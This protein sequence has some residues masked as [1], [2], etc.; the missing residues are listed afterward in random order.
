[1][2]LKTKAYGVTHYEGKAKLLTPRSD[3]EIEVRF[4][5]DATAFNGKK[6]AVFPGKGELNSQITE[7]L[8]GFLERR[9][10][11]TQHLG[12]I[13]ENTLLAH[14]VTI[15]PIEA[16]A[17]FR[18]AGSLQ[19]RTGLPYGHRCDPPVIEFY[20]KDDAL[21]DPMINDS[22]VA[23]LALA[24]SETV[25]ELKTATLG[26]A[27]ELN[28]LFTRAN[29]ELFDIKFEFGR[30]AQ[31]ELLLAD[32]ISPD[33]CRLRDKKTGDV[34]DKDRFRKDLGDL[35]EGYREVYRRLKQALGEDG[36]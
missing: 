12:R 14:R 22:H 17:R 23:L 2:L 26:I 34:F 15:I 36:C 11:K 19:S 10:I 35:L 30:S 27:T 32:E 1:M 24:D 6:H 28:T 33:T 8:F 3:S 25:S 13:D 20:Y 16:I 31:G 29:F 5:D 4:K 18:V 9:G 21:G 7:E